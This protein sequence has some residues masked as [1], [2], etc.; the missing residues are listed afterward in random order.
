MTLGKQLKKSRIEKHLSQID[1]SHHLNISR[2]SISKWETDRTFPSLENLLRLSI[3]YDISPNN[4]IKYY[5]I[6]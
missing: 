1:V 2:Q 4:L 3:L 6:R 5:E